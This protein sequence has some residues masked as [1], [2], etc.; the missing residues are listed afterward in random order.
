MKMYL[1]FNRRKTTDINGES[2]IELVVYHDRTKREYISTGIKVREEQW[3]EAGKQVVRHL[4]AKDINFNL[5][6]L[7]FETEVKYRENPTKPD[8]EF[9]TF[10]LFY[11]WY[12]GQQPKLEKSTL[13]AHKQTLDHLNGYC[14]KLLW[15]KID[16]RFPELFENYLLGKDLSTNTIWKHHKHIK[17]YLQHAITYGLFPDRL[18][19]W[20][21]R[22]FKIERKS[23]KKIALT[24]EDVENIE[25]LELNSK[26]ET[27]RDMFLFGCYTGLRFSDVQNLQPKRHIEQRK[28]GYVVAL[29]RMIKVDKPVQLRL[30]SLFNGKPQNIYKKYYDSKKEFLFPYISNSEVNLVLK[31]IK[32]EAKIK[33]PL[34]FHVSRHTFLTTIAVK[35][36]DVFQVKRLGGISKTETA[37]IYINLA[38][39]RFDNTLDDIKW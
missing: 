16:K 11:E 39:E 24:D 6:K 1:V 8:L 27:V 13:T 20:P 38:D 22:G 7:I 25:K 36:K 4:Q 35:T 14:D 5:K 3:D 32:G 2:A 23:G 10:N 15:D 12:L 29:D 33:K 17:V 21:Y 26:K 18:M 34:S 28:E 37:M 31:D 19:Q 30:Y 9:K